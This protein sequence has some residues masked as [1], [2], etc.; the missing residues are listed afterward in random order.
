MKSVEVKINLMDEKKLEQLALLKRF[1]N[2]VFYAH[3][4]LFFETEFPYDDKK[5]VMS[6]L[7]ISSDA[8]S[9]QL[10]S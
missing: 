8:F 1:A 2:H 6:A 5:K 4:S 10:T 9:K 3:N 7:N